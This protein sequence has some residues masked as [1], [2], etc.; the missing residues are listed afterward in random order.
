MFTLVTERIHARIANVY[1]VMT[2]QYPNPF[3]EVLI[4]KQLE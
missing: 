4:S 3:N 1:N 2:I